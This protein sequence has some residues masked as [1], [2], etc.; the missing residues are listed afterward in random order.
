VTGPAPGAVRA[1]GSWFA[2][3]CDQFAEL[4]E[5][6]SGTGAEA[7]EH[8]DL[9]ERVQVSLREAGRLLLQ[10]FFG[11]RAAREQRLPA[12][13]GAD[14][15]ARTRAEK[16][17][18][19]ILG[20]CFGDVPVS[21]TAYRRAGAS[22]LHP[23][24]GQLNLP[25]RRDSRA[26]QKLTVIHA[27]DRSYENAA[28]AVERATGQRPGKRQ[29]EEMM[30]AAAADYRDFYAS[31]QYRPPGLAA[32]DVLALECDAK[33]IVVLPREMRPDWARKSR[34]SAPKQD[35]RLSRGEVRNR[36]RMAETGA[37]F[38]VTPVPRTAGDILRPPDGT[39]AAA[40]PPA[41]DTPRARDKRVTASIARPAA[42]VAADAFAEA[43]RRDPG[44]EH[45]WIALADGNVHQLTRIRAEADARGVTLTIICD[46][47]HVIEYLWS[48]AWC[49]FPEASPQAGPWVRQYATAV[50]EGQATQ[51]AATIRDQIT[52]ADPALTAAKR[53]Q[54]SAAAGYLDAKAPYLNYRQ[55]LR[56][57]WPISSGVIEGTCRHLVKDRMDITGARW[58]VQGAEA[59]LKIR[60]LLASG[61]FDAYWAYH[62]QRERERNHQTRY[63]NGTIPRAA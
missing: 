15:M 59:V 46:F 28:D 38:A 34:K 13:T 16:G 17:R 6:L 21:R 32:R 56:S 43:D 27:A 22:D 31:G 60:A 41:T 14:G 29:A 47:V 9:E 3:A 51:V 23:A 25:P 18:S 39:P 37:V 50:L 42:E 7:M 1:A 26:M 36:K 61:D 44:R 8:Q 20:T 49:F 58:T 10:G 19:R 40:G 30:I 11:L 24:D 54:A 33:G 55:A 62:L 57:G 4:T 45:T 2:P 35:G 52:T 48:A 63:L 5:F 12:V 53:K